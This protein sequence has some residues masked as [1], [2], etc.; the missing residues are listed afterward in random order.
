MKYKTEAYACRNCPQI[1]ILLI[2]I[3]FLLKHTLQLMFS[4]I[5]DKEIDA[6]HYFFLKKKTRT[7][8]K[9]QLS[10]SIEQNTIDLNF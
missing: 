9:P 1:N 10:G 3:E 5:N 7:I 6:V 8:L 2:N 4:L